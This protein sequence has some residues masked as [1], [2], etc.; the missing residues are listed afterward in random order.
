M[1]IITFILRLLGASDINAW[2]ARKAFS[3][4]M[5]DADM[6]IRTPRLYRR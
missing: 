2:E 3:G 6:N 1:T 5:E 4:S